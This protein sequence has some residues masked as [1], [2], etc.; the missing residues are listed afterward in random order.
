MEFIRIWKTFF[1]YFFY[2]IAKLNLRLTKPDRAITSVS[3]VQ[4]NISVNI[5]LFFQASLFPDKRGLAYYDIIIFY[6]LFFTI[7]Y[8]NIKIYKGMYEKFDERWG[9]E[10][11]K[12]KIIGMFIVMGFILFSF[13]LYFING[14]IFDRFKKY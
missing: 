9:N 6:A 8:F 11:R 12:K 4:L 5:F 10:S 2:R 1:E 7:D 13:G 3:L 14:W